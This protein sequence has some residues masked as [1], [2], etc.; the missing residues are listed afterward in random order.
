MIRSLLEL[1]GLVEETENDEIFED[2]MEDEHEERKQRVLSPAPPI[3]S[4]VICRGDNCLENREDLAEV[5]RQGKIIIAD[6]REIEREPGQTFLDFIC[7]VAYAAHGSVA[8][9]APGI[10]IVSPRKSMIEEWEY[11]VDK[12]CYHEEEVDDLEGASYRS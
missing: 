7:G 2:L 1:L 10:F 4:V 9:L 5:L 6:L 3:V 11:S 8:R 12:E